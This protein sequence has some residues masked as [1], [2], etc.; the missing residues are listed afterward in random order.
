MLVGGKHR[1]FG[2]IWGWVVGFCT[3]PPA[4]VCVRFV[5]VCVMLCDAGVC[6]SRALM[7]I[8][9]GKFWILGV[10]LVDWLLRRLCLF[11]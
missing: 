4:C 2:G 8:V 11:V 5:L 3:P 9:S 7:G 6:Y 1:G 10:L